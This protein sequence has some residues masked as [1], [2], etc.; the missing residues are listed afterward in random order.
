M[1]WRYPILISGGLCCSVWGFIYWPFPMPGNDPV[2]DLVLY[3]TPSFYGWI[4]R[5]YYAAP[6]VAFIVGGLV[7]ISVW[8]V[9]FE[10]MGGSL[11]ALKL[12]PPWPLSADKDAGPGIVVGRFT[13]RSKPSKSAT[14]PG[15]LSR[16]ADSTP[17]WQFSVLSGPARPRLHAPVRGANLVLAG[18]QSP[19]PGGWPD[20]GSQGRLLP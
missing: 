19:A 8:R 20:P 4:V 15:S 10:D 12:L 7:L 3:H 13:T 11:T 16:S 2:L 14:L 17:E 18:R 6:A 1:K 9:W 5:W